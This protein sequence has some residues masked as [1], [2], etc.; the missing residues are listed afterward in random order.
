MLKL[1]HI[2]S[3][4]AAVADEFHIKS[5]VLFGSYANGTNTSES[6][7]DLLIEFDTSVVSLLTLSKLKHRIEDILQTEVDIIHA[8]LPENSMIEIGKG[9]QIY[10][11]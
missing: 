9:I 6:D 8:P 2:I 10:A 7:V 1:E 5:V 4:V 11:A 3:T